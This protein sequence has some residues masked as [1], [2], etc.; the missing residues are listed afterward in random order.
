MLSEGQ[1]GARLSFVDGK[2]FLD[3]I[4]NDGGDPIVLVKLMV[5][6]RKIVRDKGFEEWFAI[7]IDPRTEAVLKKHGFSV[8][9][10]VLKQKVIR[11]GS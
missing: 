2:A 9:Q 3:R 8:E 6:A 7:A 11:S 1:A 4:E 10:V 5:R